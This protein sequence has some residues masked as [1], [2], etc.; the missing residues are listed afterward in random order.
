MFELALQSDGAPVSIKSIAERQ[1]ISETYLEQL[2]QKL[3]QA[4]LLTSLRGAQGGYL[5]AK[6]PGEISVGD[7]LKALE[8]PLTPAD[9]VLGNCANSQ[10]C[11]T[12]AIWCRIYDGINTVVDSITLGQMLEDYQPQIS[13]DRTRCK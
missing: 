4:G 3:R 11:V 10:D 12:R 6:P 2:F 13:A 5:L 7:I 1:S 8:G 9:C